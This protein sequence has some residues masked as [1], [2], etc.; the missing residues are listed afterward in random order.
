MAHKLDNSK[1]FSAF[2]GYKESAWHGLGTI[3]NERITTNECLKLSGMDFIVNKLPNVHKISESIQIESEKSFFT[4]RTDCNKVLGTSVGRQYGIV[5]NEDALGV[6]DQIMQNNK[7]IEIETAGCLDD[8]R[9]SFLTLK[10]TQPVSVAKGDDY[11]QYIL[12]VNSFDGTTPI[13]CLYTNIRVVCWNTFSAALVGRHK[14]YSYVIKHT[15]TSQSRMKEALNILAKQ[16][17]IEKL[18]L[19]A[20]QRMHGTP[21]T[22]QQMKDFAF[23]VLLNDT[24]IT[25]IQQGKP[26]ESTKADKGAASTRKLNMID[27]ILEFTETG[28]GQDMA[29]GTAWNAFQG[30]TGF[31]SNVRTYANSQDRFINLTMPTGTANEYMLKSYDLALN[32]KN[33]RPVKALSTAANVPMNLN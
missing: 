6:V 17:E 4:Y 19:E 31:F 10:M 16:K 23:N 2:V 30:V 15:A 13:M 9:I 21:F 20:F 28:I 32:P 3:V 5:Q 18:S 8:G 26:L 22:S 33:I 7:N 11:F 25:A 24:E 14:G 12:V 29:R 27:G 1:G